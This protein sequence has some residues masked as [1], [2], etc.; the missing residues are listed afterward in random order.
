MKDVLPAPH[1]VGEISTLAEYD[2]IA[3]L[4]MR[5]DGDQYN[6][7]RGRNAAFYL[8]DKCVEEG[9]ECVEPAPGHSR[10]SYN[11]LAV[12]NGWQVPPDSV[13]RDNH[14]RELGD[15]LWCLTRSLET[16]DVTI[17]DIADWW[18]MQRDGRHTDGTFEQLDKLVL[19]QNGQAEPDRFTT[20]IKNNTAL[21]LMKGVTA[22]RK[23]AR[24]A[25]GLR[26]W[27][28]ETHDR[29]VAAGGML[30]ATLGWIAHNR[31]GIALQEVAQ[32]NAVK[33]CIRNANGSVFGNGDDINRK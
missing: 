22:Y 6:T 1:M 25:I 10:S 12:L 14:A 4:S 7:I 29:L 3:F 15:V 5:T 30:L 21:F 19:V 17:L 20:D 18:I 32:Q 16:F 27:S 26:Y 9:L 11:R 13:E 24:A 2:R 28:Q 23:T 8:I 31:F 33:V